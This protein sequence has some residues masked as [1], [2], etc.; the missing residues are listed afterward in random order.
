MPTTTRPSF[1]GF[2]RYVEK[3][4]LRVRALERGARAG[5][6]LTVAEEGEEAEAVALLDVIRDFDARLRALEAR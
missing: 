5:V 2:Q 3:I 6:M 4:E 1:T